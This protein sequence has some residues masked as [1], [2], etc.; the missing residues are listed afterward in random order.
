VG[1]GELVSEGLFEVP[2]VVTG[3]AGPGRVEAGVLRSVNAAWNNGKLIDED[4]GMVE[5]ALLAARALDRAERLPDKSAVYAVAQLMRPWQDAM[6]ALR[7]PEE[8]SPVPAP[9][10]LAAETSD[11]TPNWLRDLGTPRTD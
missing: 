3:P 11:G 5:G 9:R 8:V 10:A 4:A 7:L 1:G 2:E 6:H